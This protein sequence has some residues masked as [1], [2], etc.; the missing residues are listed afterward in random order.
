MWENWFLSDEP[1]YRMLS[2]TG[3]D[4]ESFL[5]GQL[6]QDIPHIPENKACWTASC[7]YQGRVA[8][9]ALIFRIPNGFGLLVR[10]SIAADEVTRLK[11]YV[12]RSKVQLS[13]EDKSVRFMSSSKTTLSCPALPVEKLNTYQDSDVTVIRLSGERLSFIV[14]GDIPHVFEGIKRK[15]GVLKQA[16]IQDGIALIDKK[17]TLK[18][19]PQ[20]LNLDIIE[21]VSFK[22]G[23]YT[24]QE[25]I[26]RA[27]HVG[28]KKRRMYLASS[29]LNN[30][31]EGEEIF[32]GSN[33]VGNIIQSY[34]NEFLC[35]IQTDYVNTGLSLHGKEI[36]K[37]N[38]PYAVSL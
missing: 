34:G 25:V 24:G 14:I 9:T 21:A 33:S 19:M 16:L 12:L 1:E 15:T 30:P 38:L 32:A 6:T 28:S 23:C 35:V 20:A 4:A 26:A 10:A 3:A 36:R 27:Q 11:K 29:D 13:V 17:E 2:V 5:Q 8:S 31:A 18:W 7:N 37:L 22:K